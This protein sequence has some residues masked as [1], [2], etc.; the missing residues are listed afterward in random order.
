MAGE[1]PSSAFVGRAVELR[2]LDEVLDRAEQESPQV[3][4]LAGDA[5]VARP[6]CCWPLPAALVGVGCGC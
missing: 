4:L 1:L 2:R 6:A 5:G 3:V